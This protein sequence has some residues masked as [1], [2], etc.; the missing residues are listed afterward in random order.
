VAS[1]GKLARSAGGELVTLVL[2]LTKS[3]AGLASQHGGLS[4]GVSITFSAPGEPTLR[5]S[6]A[7]SFR[8]TVSASRRSAKGHASARTGR[9]R[10]ARPR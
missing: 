5:Q 4:A 8:R 6:I 3:Y 10:G 2:S 7:V 9:K 1:A